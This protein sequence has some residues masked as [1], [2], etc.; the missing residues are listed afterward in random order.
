MSGR[1]ASHAAARAAFLIAACV[2]LGGCYASNVVEASQRE[3]KVEQEKVTWRPSVEADVPGFYESTAVEGAAAGALLKAYYYL[4][5][6]GD[7]S[8]GVLVVS[9]EGPRF[10][11]LAEN[12]RYEFAAGKID[13]KDGSG[14]VPLD[15]APDQ[16]R[17][18]SPET[19]IVFRRVELR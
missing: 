5:P 9:P 16:I 17:L 15:A 12:G 19:T 6:E 3:V 2:G 13:L 14:P 8:G 11:V 18:R 4:G 7:Y 10:L 1:G